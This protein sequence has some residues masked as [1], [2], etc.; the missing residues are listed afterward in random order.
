VSVLTKP[1]CTN[2]N[3]KQ[4]KQLWTITGTTTSA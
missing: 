1:Q 4:W 3:K 2:N